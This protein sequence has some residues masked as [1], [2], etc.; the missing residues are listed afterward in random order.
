M[1][2]RH[3]IGKAVSEEELDELKQINERNRSSDEPNV[4]KILPTMQTGYNKDG[5]IKEENIPSHMYEIND[6]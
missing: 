4:V 2:K 1:V 6:K 3:M 5:T